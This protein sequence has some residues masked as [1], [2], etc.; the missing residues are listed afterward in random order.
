[1]KRLIPLCL[2]LIVLLPACAPAGTLAPAATPFVQPTPTSFPPALPDP[3]PGTLTVYPGIDLGPI[4]PYLFGTNYG[5]MQAIVA[6]RVPDVAQAGFTVLRFPG[7]AV[8]DQLDVIG[9][10]I[11]MFIDLCKQVGAIPTISVR[12][13]GGTPEIAAE[14]VRYTNIEKKYGVVYWSIGNEPSLYEDQYNEPY[15][16]IMFN[17]QWRAIALA[18]EAVDPAIQLIGPE[19]HQWND[20]LATTVKDNAGR[21]WMTEFLKA[22]GDMVDIV[23]VHR[24]PMYSPTN[25]PVTVQQLREDTR[26][27]PAQIAYLRSLVNEITGRDL[28]LAW[29]EVNSDPSAVMF[30]DVSPELVLQRH[31]VRRR[32]R[33][34]YERQGLHGQ[35]VGHL[36]AQHRAGA[37]LRLHHPPDFLRLSHV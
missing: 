18:M 4:S 36:A 25:G 21:D 19:I 16:T 20:S 37:A 23:T 9:L 8:G 33:P 3:T 26:R 12:L 31:L 35:P 2:I 22:N 17:Q 30:Q 5:P 24:Y 29:T 6:D 28:P 1:M 14:M 11:D 15:D 10:Q 34:V 13:R 32:A 7:G 27:W